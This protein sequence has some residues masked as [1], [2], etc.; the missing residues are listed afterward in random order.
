MKKIWTAVKAILDKSGEDELAIYAA[1]ASFFIVTSTLPLMML[2][3]SA[4]SFITP[5]TPESLQEVLIDLTPIPLHAYV[6]KICREMFAN[7]SGTVAVV[8]AII[9]LFTASRS[10]AG[11]EQ[12][13]TRI[14][15]T[16]P[17]PGW[18]R[19]R[20]VNM[21]YTLAMIVLII[22][23]LG[24]FALGDRLKIL[25]ATI[26]PDFPIDLELYGY[27]FT[28]RNVV[29]IGILFLFF[30]M[31][32]KFLPGKFPDGR[33]LS[34]IGQVPGAVFATAG[35]VIF[36]FFYSLYSN[37]MDR[38]YFIYGSL[39]ALILL[40]VWLYFCMSIV[41]FG[42]EVNFYFAELWQAHLDR[43][44]EK[45]QQRRRA[46]EMKKALHTAQ[47]RGGTTQEDKEDLPY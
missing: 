44:E 3:F 42:A 22:F 20:A 15:G 21:G 9:V 11:I 41:F 16:V 30:L 2:L 28:V 43:R 35:W 24:V 47:K 5:I 39:T 46:A 34:L 25:L 17:R 45:R 37:N 29:V 14:Y 36:S 23:F 6:E 13:L 40:L 32:Y 33:R 26:W 31:M 27:T 19:R 12:G 38:L 18:L 1:Q 8:T 10:I 4:I 7:A